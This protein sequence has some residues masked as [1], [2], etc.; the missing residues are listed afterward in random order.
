MFIKSTSLRN[1]VVILG[2]F[3]ESFTETVLFLFA[4]FKLFKP[5]QNWY[6]ISLSAVVCGKT[7]A[8]IN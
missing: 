2:Q 1:L 8:G 6:L 3:L 5:I 7:S 4:V